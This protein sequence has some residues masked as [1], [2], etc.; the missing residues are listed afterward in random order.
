MQKIAQI[1]RSNDGRTEQKVFTR[2][3]RNFLKISQLHAEKRGKILKLP[4]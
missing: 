2:V 3:V 1:G 4:L